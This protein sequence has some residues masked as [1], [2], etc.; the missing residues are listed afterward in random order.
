MELDVLLEKLGNLSTGARFKPHKYILLLVILDFVGSRENAENKFY[1]DGK[2]KEN[3]TRYFDQYSREGD[4]NRPYTPFYHLQ[5]SGFWF[6]QPRWGKENVLRQLKTVGG[7]SDIEDNVEYAY[8]SESVFNLF[9]NK[10]S[11]NII[12]TIILSCLKKN[13]I[14]I[15]MIPCTK[16]L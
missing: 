15:K 6:L 11:A 10:D 5:S 2:L 16:L 4:S 8:L 9:K 7:S 1:F 12:R 14:Q 13:K 3:F